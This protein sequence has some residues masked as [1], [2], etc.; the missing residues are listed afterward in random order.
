[1]TLD[2]GF[3]ELNK[4]GMIA[5]GSMSLKDKIANAKRFNSDNVLD[6]IREM[7]KDLNN[8]QCGDWKFR[9]DSHD[10][11]CYTVV[12]ENHELS[13]DDERIDEIEWDW[14]PEDGI[15]NALHYQ[16]GYNVSSRLDDD[17]FSAYTVQQFMDVI[18]DNKYV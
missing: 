8:G 12:G 6:D 14:F 3:K 2:E 5:E 15:V 16:S 1:M 18:R 7:I 4:A 11:E 13:D 9:L 10:P 17:R